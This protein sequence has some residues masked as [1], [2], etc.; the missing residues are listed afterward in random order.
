MGL[1][2]SSP[3]I[4]QNKNLNKNR[5]FFLKNTMI[6][7]PLRGLPFS[8]IQPLKSTD[9][10]YSVILK[11]EVIKLEAREYYTVVRSWNI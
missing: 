3:S 4:F 2:G 8:L 9:D 6:P 10:Q 11:N 5:D 7:K 1:T